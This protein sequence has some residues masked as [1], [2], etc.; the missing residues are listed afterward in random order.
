LAGQRSRATLIIA[1]RQCLTGTIPTNRWRTTGFIK[2]ACVARILKFVEAKTPRK[3]KTATKK[4]PC[5]T[6]YFS[7]HHNKK[8]SRNDTLAQV[9]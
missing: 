9:L 4:Q 2:G 8:Y 6:R 1:A 7:M 3:D 5:V